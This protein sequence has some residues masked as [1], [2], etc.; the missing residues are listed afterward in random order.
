MSNKPPYP[1][2]LLLLFWLLTAG[3]I[4][5]AGW[6][7]SEVSE[8]LAMLVALPGLLT[9]FCAYVGTMLRAGYDIDRL[10]PKLPSF[11]IYL[12]IGVHIA[13]VITYNIAT[14]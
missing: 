13:A 2:S 11:K 6:V 5:A 14:N 10:F 8:N 7:S 12:G 4:F 1:W 9:G 3:I